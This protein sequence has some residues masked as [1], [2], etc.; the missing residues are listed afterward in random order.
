M[1]LAGF[2]ID[3]D[4]IK[5]EALDA[6]KLNK[7]GVMVP[8]EAIWYNDGEIVNDKD[9]EGDWEEVGNEHSPYTYFR[10]SSTSK[11]TRVEDSSFAG[12]R[13]SDCS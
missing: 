4:R 3:F 1:S 6:M 8:E 2:S 9:F 7:A 10:I 13:W 11:Y 5:V 12:L